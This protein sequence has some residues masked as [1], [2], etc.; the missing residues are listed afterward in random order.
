MIALSVIAC[1]CFVKLVIS[2]LSFV[3]IVE[4][5]DLIHLNLYRSLVRLL[6]TVL[7]MQILEIIT[8][9]FLIR[10]KLRTPH[11]GLH[12]E[13]FVRIAIKSIVKMCI[14]PKKLASVATLDSFLATLAHVLKSDMF[15]NPCLGYRN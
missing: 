2:S 8:L 6:F 12:K 7:T 9:Q 13:T 5:S 3:L 10:I 14:K 1:L 15:L 4:F 11:S